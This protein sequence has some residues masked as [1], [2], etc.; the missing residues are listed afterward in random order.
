VLSLVG[1][2]TFAAETPLFSKKDLYSFSPRANDEFVSILV[3]K[4]NLLREAGITT[5]LPLAHFFAQIATETGGL[6]RLD[7]NLNY[8]KEG[9]IKN[10]SRKTVSVEKASQIAGKP[11]EIANW[12]YGGRLGNKGK[13]T[14]DGWDYRGSGFIQ[15]TGRENF[16]DRGQEVQLP[17]EADPSLAR[18]PYEGLLAATSY[19]KARK[20]ND[21]AANNDIHK[22][23]ILVNGKAANGLPQAKI[24]FNKTS[25]V[26]GVKGGSEKEDTIL[27]EA[28]NESESLSATAEALGE[29]GFLTQQE[30]SEGNEQTVSKA[31]RA[32][33]KSRGL[34]ETGTLDEDT[35]YS[36]TDPQEWR[37]DPAEDAIGD[38]PHVIG[39]PEAT[40]TYDMASENETKADPTIQTSAS[41]T[42]NLERG[43]GVYKQGQDAQI[44][45]QEISFFVNSKATYAPYEEEKGFRDKKGNFIPFS[46]IGKDERIEVPDTR[47]FPARAIVQIRFTSKT[48]G[49]SRLCTGAMVS[50]NTVLTAGHCVH[51]GT[52]SGAWYS[53]FTIYPGR[54]KGTQPFG[55]CIAEKL[56]TISG[57]ARAESFD[58]ARQ[59]DLGAIKLNC[60]VGRRTGWFNLKVVKDNETDLPTIVQGYPADRTPAGQWISKDKIRQIQNLNVFY[61]NDTFGGMSGSP[62]YTEDE[63]AIFAIHTSGLHGSEPW[64]KYNGATR[65]TQERLQ[66]IMSWIQN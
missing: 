41:G 15:L 50:S 47:N 10:F 36:I 55:S 2:V 22:I 25:K 12:V 6:Q 35:L 4:Q 19:W 5:G 40:I 52:A 31:L 11:I 65:I 16:R 13:H 60:D 30:S 14:S 27:L 26:F 1:N 8:S 29:L 54:K 38:V 33:Q 49:L 64:S 53:N 42:P 45:P 56:N 39:N 23:R 34:Q 44:S 46:I 18:K 59:Y 37:G 57:W 3:E 48:D 17:L 58:E 28:A 43:T 32:Y 21:A 7:E 20:I 66:T 51:S 61:Q 24:W 9:L 63:N 62:V